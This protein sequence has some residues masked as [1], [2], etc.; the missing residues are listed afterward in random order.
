MKTITDRPSSPQLLH[1]GAR[2]THAVEHQTGADGAAA[3][4]TADG[5]AAAATAEAQDGSVWVYRDAWGENGGGIHSFQCT[6]YTEET[7]PSR[8]VCP[9]APSNTPDAAAPAPTLQCHALVHLSPE[10]LKPAAHLQAVR[11]RGS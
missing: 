6:N 5:A 3:A 7:H 9:V 2:V 10:A 1:D 8:R 11:I 4:A